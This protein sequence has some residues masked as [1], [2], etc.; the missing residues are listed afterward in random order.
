MTNPFVISSDDHALFRIEH[1]M[2]SKK[3]NYITTWEG[4]SV[5]YKTQ[6]EN[7]KGLSQHRMITIF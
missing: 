1:H 4:L 3:G 6:H 5:P 7:K 2:R